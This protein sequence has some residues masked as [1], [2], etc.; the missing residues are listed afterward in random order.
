MCVN[1]FVYVPACTRVRVCVYV[2]LCVYHAFLSVIV[3]AKIENDV[4]L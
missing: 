3:T 4:C 2:H 1:A